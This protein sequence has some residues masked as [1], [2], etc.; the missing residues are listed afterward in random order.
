MGTWSR[1]PLRRLGIT[2]LVSVL[3]LTAAGCT[4]GDDGGGSSTASGGKSVLKFAYS[5]DY[6]FLTPEA[7]KK[8]W[9]DVKAE[10]EKKYPN[11]TVEINAIPGGYTDFVT[12][13]S[14]LYRDPSTAPD[15]SQIPT[16]QIGGWVN[17]G[18]FASLNDK[19]SSAAWWAD[20][21]DSVKALDT[22]DGTVY[23]ANQGVNTTGL[24]YN[25]PV[26]EKA[27]IAVPWQPQTWQD[28]IDAGQKIKD[29]GQDVWPTEWIGGVGSGVS[30]FQ[31][32]AQ[33]MFIGSSAPQAQSADG[34]WIVDSPGIRDVLQ[35]Y[36][37]LSDKG[38]AAPTNVLLDPNSIYNMFADLAAQK[39]GIL[40]TGNWMGEVWTEDVCAPCWPEGN[41]TIGVAR[42]PT[43][44]GTANAANT[45][46]SLG[47]WDLTIGAKSQ[48]FDA[49]WN[50]IDV[51]QQ[52]QNAINLANTGGQVVTQTKLATNPKFADF[53]PPYQEFFAKIAPDAT[54]QNGGIDGSS[55]N[56]WATGFMQAT[57]AI[58]QD[59]TTT[60][61]Q[62]AAI[63]KDYV[64][65]Q[66]G[67]DKV[68]T[69]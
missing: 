46:S 60:V 61:D 34:K 51:A 5:Q 48:N 66:L 25:M 16:E 24:W 57:G 9:G 8:Y 4:R 29:S 36:K 20:I 10:Y 21:P 26:F 50:F 49:A 30:G 40:I 33:P 15:V 13:M 64:T 35:F 37:D 18:Y 59:P 14:L 52:E 69:Q 19:V 44:N 2:A 39:M 23:A 68:T 38:I 67:Q 11:V 42:I 53:A 31:F 58:I 3:A 54:G 12:K 7:G 1:S 41:K 27:G 55:Y 63:M 43:V 62:A 45:A 47:G 6:M 28:I 17:S 22:F 56:I 32:S 65:G